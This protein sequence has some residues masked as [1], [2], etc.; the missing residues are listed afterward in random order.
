MV[1]PAAADLLAWA[2]VLCLGAALARCE[3]AAFRYRVLAVAAR[4]VRTGR[5]W[6]LRRSPGSAPSAVA[7][8]AWAAEV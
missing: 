3:P 2:Q 5:T 4:L 7:R 1:L 6:R 8:L